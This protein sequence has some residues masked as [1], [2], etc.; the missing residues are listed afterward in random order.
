M[1]QIKNILV[2]LKKNK[3]NNWLLS[4]VLKDNLKIL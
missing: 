4:L 2:E 3:L 1:F